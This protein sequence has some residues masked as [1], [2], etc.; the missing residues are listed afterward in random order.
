MNITDEEIERFFLH[1][2]IKHKIAKVRFW[3]FLYGFILGCILVFLPFWFWGCSSHE[4]QPTVVD[5]QAETGESVIGRSLA[6]S[7]ASIQNIQVDEAF[8]DWLDSSYTLLLIPK[9]SSD[10]LRFSLSDVPD[11]D[12]SLGLPIDS[13]VSVRS[14]RAKIDLWYSLI[15]SDSAHVQI[16]PYLV[17]EHDTLGNITGDTTITIMDVVALIQR[18]VR[19]YV[20]HL[21][22]PNTR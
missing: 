22:G 21:F 15:T 2:R 1:L 7:T 13:I 19:P 9:G 4:K 8:L 17:I 16:K 5:K 14:N 12:I 18:D 11:R 20:N 6:Y 10:T 3:S